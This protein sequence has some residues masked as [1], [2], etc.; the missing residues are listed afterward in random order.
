MTQID[1]TNFAMSTQFDWN[2]L[3]FDLSPQ[4]QKHVTKVYTNLTTLLLSACCGAVLDVYYGIGGTLTSLAGFGLLLGFYFT[5]ELI[6]YDRARLLLHGFAL[7]QGISIGSLIDYVLYLNPA[8]IVSALG[9]TA[10]LFG[11]FTLSVMFSPRRYHFYVAG[12]LSSGVSMLLWL[13]FINLFFRSETA[14]HVELYLG[15]C[16]FALFVVYDTQIMIAKAERGSR[17][18]LRHSLELFSDVFG[19]FVR[20]LVILSKKEE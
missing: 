13:Q 15:L 19:I 4:V 8:I 3:E 12:L 16:V 20:L 1:A 9:S 17:H 11:S 18:V 2:S 10:I 14:F 7:C 5:D 6:Q